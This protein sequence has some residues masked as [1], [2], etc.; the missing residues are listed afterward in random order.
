MKRKLLIVEDDPNH[1][2]L[3]QLAL[4]RSGYQ[5]ELVIV[6]DGMELLEYLFRQGRYS[7][8]TRQDMPDLIFLDL[9]LPNMDGLTVLRK[10]KSDG[11]TRSIPIVMLSSSNEEADIINSYNLGANSYVCKRIDATEF[12]EILKSILSYW[13]DFVKL[14]PRVCVEKAEV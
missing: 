14:P 2:V 11:R 10:L 13:F 5:P 7:A 12:R 1:A 4:E 9:K 8:L 6:Q 3:T